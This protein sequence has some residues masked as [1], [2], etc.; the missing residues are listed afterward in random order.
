[1]NDTAIKRFEVG[2]RVS[3]IKGFRKGLTG[4]IKEVNESLHPANPSR[5]YKVRFSI[6]SQFGY[7][8]YEYG[9]YT[10]DEIEMIPLNM[11]FN[12]ESK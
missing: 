1:M 4:V 9:W 6:K 3:P 12:K 7:N 10:G 11:G 5:T 8:D 2:D